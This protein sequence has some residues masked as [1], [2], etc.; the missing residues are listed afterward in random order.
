M[1][2]NLLIVIIITINFYHVTFFLQ[3]CRLFSP[4]MHSSIWCSAIIILLLF[5]AVQY[6]DGKLPWCIISVSS[7][8]KYILVTLS[9]C[10]WLNVVLSLG[11]T[12]VQE[13]DFSDGEMEKESERVNKLLPCF[14]FC[15]V[16]CF[17]FQLLASQILWA[18]FLYS[19]CQLR[20]T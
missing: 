1:N 19:V 14:L 18:W 10:K 7:L 6:G 8:P 12:G 9:T 2:L 20:V 15:L 11:K 17:L 3:R 4:I 5:L 16:C 13:K